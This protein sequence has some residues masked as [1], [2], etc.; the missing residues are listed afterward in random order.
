[1]LIRHL[2]RQVNLVQRF[3]LLKSFCTKFRNDSRCNEQKCNTVHCK[4]NRK[5]MSTVVSFQDLLQQ[6][7]W[8][9]VARKGLQLRL[10]MNAHTA[11]ALL[12]RTRRNAKINLISE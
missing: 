2:G 4:I 6:S 7:L 3:V 1:M 8:L 11:S 5:K 10:F 9:Q 12:R